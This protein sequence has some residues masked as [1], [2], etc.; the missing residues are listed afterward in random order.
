MKPRME[1]MAPPTMTPDRTSMM[2]ESLFIADGMKTVRATAIMPPTNAK[3][4]SRKPEKPSRIAMAAPMQA[5][6]ETPRK[7]GEMSGFLKMLWYETPDMASMMP[8][9][10]DAVMRGSRRPMTTLR[11][12]SEY[13]PPRWNSS[14]KRTSMLSFAEIGYF[15]AQSATT[16]KPAKIASK[17][18]SKPTA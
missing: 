4:D 3:P 11:V 1:L 2:F 12:I 10:M 18:R 7:S 5:P 6:L 17:S 9:R 8:T 16:T 13:S 14:P 15:P